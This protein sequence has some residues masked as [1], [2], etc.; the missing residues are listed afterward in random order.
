MLGI[1]YLIHHSNL[2]TLISASQQGHWSA[3]LYSE[4]I[5]QH[6]SNLFML[7]FYCQKMLTTQIFTRKKA[8]CGSRV[9]YLL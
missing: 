9:L 5:I 4:K 6:I 1:Q 7:S 3:F 2:D 8:D